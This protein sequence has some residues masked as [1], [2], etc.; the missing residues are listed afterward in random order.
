MLKN[1]IGSWWK[2]FVC[3]KNKLRAETSE[4]RQGTSL[5]VPVPCHYGEPKMH[6][7]VGFLCRDWCHLWQ[8]A[9]ALFMYEHCCS[10]VLTHTYGIAMDVLFLKSFFMG[11]RNAA[12]FML[13]R[14]KSKIVPN[15]CCYLGI[16]PDRHRRYIELTSSQIFIASLIC[17]LPRWRAFAAHPLAAN[18]INY[19]RWV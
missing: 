3:R 6:L 12:G 13:L 16:A 10:K 17:S 15:E 19:L 7:S 5:V 8:T 2:L 14:E 1:V 11:L 9:L 4:G 18:N